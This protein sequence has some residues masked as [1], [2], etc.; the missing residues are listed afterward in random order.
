[1]VRGKNKKTQIHKI[2]TYERDR[3]KLANLFK[4]SK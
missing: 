4:S 3:L 2:C 1:M